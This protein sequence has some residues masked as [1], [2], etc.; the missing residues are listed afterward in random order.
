MR[1]KIKLEAKITKEVDVDISFPAFY[2]KESNL[3]KQINPYQNIW[4][5]D[6]DICHNYLGLDYI[7]ENESIYKQSTS[8]EFN[9]ALNAA[10]THVTE[11]NKQIN[12]N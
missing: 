12:G 4:I 6:K 5:K 3:I 10:I 8:E 2:K 7:L 11:L 1:F 9:K